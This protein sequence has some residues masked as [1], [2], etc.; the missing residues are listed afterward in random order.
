MKKSFFESWFAAHAKVPLRD[1][2]EIAKAKITVNF[3]LFFFL[4]TVAM[5]PVISTYDIAV[6][7]ALN[8]AALVFYIIPLALL[9]FGYAYTSAATVL[10]LSLIFVATMNGLM[11]NGA[12]SLTV[13]IWYYLILLFAGYVLPPRRSLALLASVF[14]IAASMSVAR[15]FRLIDFNP[16]YDSRKD[17]LMACACLVIAFPLAAKL[18]GEYARTK[19]EAVSQLH[20]TIESKNSILGV[21]AHDLRNSVGSIQSVLDLIDMELEEGNTEGAVKL[22]EV[23]REASGASMDQISELV[24]AAEMDQ[25]DKPMIVEPVDFTA[26]LDSALGTCLPSAKK[27]EVNVSFDSPSQ[28]IIV[29]INKMK[30]TRVVANLLSNAVKFTHTGGTI[31]VCIGTDSEGA[32]L[33]SVSDNGVGIPEE[34]R[35]K[36][37]DRFTSSGRPGTEQ[38]R[39]FGLGMSIVKELVER[40]RGSIWFE[41]SVD[42]AHHG[43]S[44]HIRLPAASHAQLPESALPNISKLSPARKRLSGFQEDWV[45]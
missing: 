25:G 29:E 26:F 39:S 14:A 19:R 13:T 40:H 41:T 11:N 1:E 42:E 38:E 32:A 18:I 4:M 10:C 43:T 45:D 6:F 2:F 30:F 27:K 22:L 23:I 24:D 5:I 20:K 8:F 3:S 21:V 35:D 33:L 37:F 17:A 31:H 28:P 12:L 9:R 7:A 36:L 44:F 15:F 16:F 34:L